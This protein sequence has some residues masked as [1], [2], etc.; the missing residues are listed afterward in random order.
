MTRPSSSTAVELAIMAFLLLAIA[1]QTFSYPYTPDLSHDIGEEDGYPYYA[2]HLDDGGSLIPEY[3]RLPGYSWFLLAS[4]RLTGFYYSKAGQIVQGILSVLTFAVLWRP[5]RRVFGPLTTVLLFALFAAPNLWVRLSAFAFPDYLTALLWFAFALAVL[6]WTTVTAITGQ[7]A[8]AAVALALAGAMILLK[9]GMLILVAIFG[10]AMIGAQLVTSRHWKSVGPVAA[11]AG[12]LLAGAFALQT[13][14]LA[15]CGTGSLVF[16]RNAMHARIA[17]YLPPASDSPAEQTVES[18]KAGIA[19]REGQRMEDENFTNTL[20]VVQPAVEEVWRARLAARP[21]DYLAVMLDELRR[22]HDFVAMSFAPF[23]ADTTPHR[24]RIPPRDSTL[25]SRV[26]RASGFHLP[27]IGTGVP[28]TAAALSK[29][30]ARTVL[31]WVPLIWGL[32][33]LHRRWPFATLTC[34]FACAA[35]VPALAFGIFIDGRYLLPFAPLIYLAQAVGLAGLVTSLFR[36][37]ATQS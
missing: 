19:A 25:A 21:S 30:V 7:V 29:G 14:I 15:V 3:R 6:R 13:V 16:Y 5:I 37:P 27:G 11:R 34:V 1:L 31:F 2:K 33:A 28:S 36:N 9:A 22:K 20:A 4:K 18:A 17:T 32:I 35:Y 26:Y 24:A 8:W 12:V 23:M 10:A